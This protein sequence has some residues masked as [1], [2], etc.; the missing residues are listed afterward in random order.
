MVNLYCDDD[1]DCIITDNDITGGYWKIGE[2][3]ATDAGGVA[4]ADPAGGLWP[5]QVRSWKYAVPGR[6]ESDPLLTVTGNINIDILC[7][8][9]NIISTVEGAPDSDRDP[10][11]QGRF[12]CIYFLLLNYLVEKSNS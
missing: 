4:T 6:W 7:L 1:D 10:A 12:V 8:N 5:H 3:P 2:D 9:N 11:P